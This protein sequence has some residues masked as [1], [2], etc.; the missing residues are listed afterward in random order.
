MRRRRGRRYRDRPG[1]RRWLLMMAAGS[2]GLAGLAG[3]AG[4]AGTPPAGRQEAVFFPP[5]PARPRL[6]YLTHFT[7]ADQVVAHRG[8]LERFVLG[9]DVPADEIAKPYGLALHGGKL[10]VCD[11]KVGAVVVFDLVGRRFG[12]LGT[13]GPQRLR[14]PMNLCVGPDGRKYVADVDRGEIVVLGPQDEW[15]GTLGKQELTAPVDVAVGDGR[16][17]VCD[18]Q[19]CRIVVLDPVTGRA[20][21]SFGGKG[22][23]PGQFARP[24]NLALDA[25]GNIYVSDTLNGRVQV[26]SPAGEFVREFGSPGTG[27]GISRGPRAWPWTT[28]AGV[29]WLTPPSR[30]CRSST[31]RGGSWP[32]SAARAKTRANSTCLPR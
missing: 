30:T 6:Q 17:Y 14:K 13:E 4:C 9:D 24:T 3:L 2:V 27:R 31:R 25:Q 32:S 16:L 18:A 1:L 12:Y 23:A 21:A 28:R 11:T 20:L 10:Y 15:V 26:L 22:Q 7:R 8:T 5:A 29:S 19:E